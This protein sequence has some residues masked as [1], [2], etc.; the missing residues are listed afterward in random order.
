[1]K[2]LVLGGAGF[3]GTNLAREALKWD[4]VEFITIVDN[5]DP[6]LGSS[7]ANLPLEDSRLIFKLGNICDQELMNIIVPMHDV[8]INCAAQTSHAISMQQPLEDVE[9]TVRGNLLVLETIRNVN[10]EVRYIYIS[11]STVTGSA[12][13]EIITEEHGEWP[14]DMYSACKAAAEKQCFIYS[15]IHGLKILTLRFANLYGPYG[16]KTKDFG[17]INY[18]ISLSSDGQDIPVYGEGGQLRNVMYV[19]DAIF[20]I[21]ACLKQESVFDGTPYFAVH[22]EHYSIGDIA[23]C[24]AEVFEQSKVVEHAWPADRAKIEVGPVT[25]SGDKLQTAIV[26]RPRYSLSEGLVETRHL[27]EQISRNES[28][29]PY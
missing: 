22:N 23:Y 18:F 4:D 13:S 28:I 10:P 24:I 11:T 1:M 19:R 15:R 6:S 27:M 20:C 25:I 21:Q 26:W 7:I 2:L 8:I 14:L 12:H 17:F 9:T 3:L 29:V 5:L 16:K